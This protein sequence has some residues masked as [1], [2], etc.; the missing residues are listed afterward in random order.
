M[1]TQKNTPWNNQTEYYGL[2]GDSK[3]SGVRNGD[4]FV[5]INTGK[6]FLY[7]E[8]GAAWVEQPASG[9]GGGSSDVSLATVTVLVSDEE[10]YNTCSIAGAIGVY[11]ES[12]DPAYFIVTKWFPNNYSQPES[13]DVIMYHG[14][15]ILQISDANHAQV[16][17]SGT[18]TQTGPTEYSCMITG[19]CSI[20]LSAGK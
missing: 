14:S 7:N 2:S 11:D 5:E 18:L 1:V 13:I 19:D 10:T 8:T 15:G 6:T 9:G 17:G 4:K 20:T 16:S 3:P 12:D